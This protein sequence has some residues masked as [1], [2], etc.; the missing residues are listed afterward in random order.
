MEMELPAAL[1]PA[2]R[3]SSIGER[4]AA[5]DVVYRDLERDT[6]SF[7]TAASLAC[8]PRC[9]GECC[10]GFV[11]D[12]FP[13][14]A[15]YLAAWLVVG[16]PGRAERVAEDGLDGGGRCPFQSDAATARCTAYPGRCLICR[17]FGFTGFRGKDGRA[18]FRACRW[19][20]VPELGLPADA[21]I[22]TLADY[23]ARVAGLTPGENRRP[24]GE[25]V[26]DAVLRIL[27][28]L[29]RDDGNRAA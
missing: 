5:L 19:M 29:S 24:L 12:V 25:A 28:I 18:A 27:Y 23:G 13:A 1:P 22:P 4:I 21:A 14:E 17:G 15:E 6:A 8:P 9:G 10:D 11:P 3:F 20:G 26:R 2:L 7:A 16:D